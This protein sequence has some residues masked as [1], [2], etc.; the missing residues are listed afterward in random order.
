MVTHNFDID[1]MSVQMPKNDLLKEAKAI[2]NCEVKNQMIQDQRNIF[3]DEMPAMNPMENNIVITEVP[4][5][6]YLYTDA[7]SS[8]LLCEF[9]YTKNAIVR[10]GAFE[11]YERCTWVEAAVRNRNDSYMVPWMNSPK[12]T[13][14]KR[15]IWVPRE[16]DG[17][18]NT[19]PD[20]RVSEEAKQMFPLGKNLAASGHDNVIFEFLQLMDPMDIMELFIL[21]NHFK[22]DQYAWLSKKKKGIEK[23]ELVT[24]N[25]SDE[26]TEDEEQK[27]PIEENENKNDEIWDDIVP[28]EHSKNK[29]GKSISKKTKKIKTTNCIIDDDGNYQRIKVHFTQF[30]AFLRKQDDYIHEYDLGVHYYFVQNGNTFKAMH[31]SCAVYVFNQNL[32]NNN[33][34]NLYSD[35][36]KTMV[37]KKEKC[38][39][40]KMGK[41][42]NL[43]IKF[44]EGHICGTNECSF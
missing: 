20:K 17:Y 6:Y 37:K 9:E 22:A 32:V 13:Q 34:T 40:Q 11:F 7:C 33:T 10:N 36:Y 23:N 35:F 26:A 16:G 42:K 8:Q 29:K 15:F 1:N 27:D 31:K 28:N 21:N 4:P 44:C 30:N 3:G 24:P 41:L 25:T 18:I 43:A 12:N 5:G 38:V 14:I 39:T 2:D 19:F